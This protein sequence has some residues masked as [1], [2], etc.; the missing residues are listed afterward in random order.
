M[1]PPGLNG[2]NDRRSV[3]SDFTEPPPPEP[4]T[5]RTIGSRSSRAMRSACTCFWKIDASA[6]PP[7]TV[8]SSPPT[9]T[10]AAVDAA[11]SHHE[12]GGCDVD[13][14]AVVVVGGAAGER[15]DLVER[16][17]IEERV[18]ALAHGE[19]ALRVMLGDLLVAAHASRERVAS[20]QLVE[21]GFP[22][23][24]GTRQCRAL[25]T[26][27]SRRTEAEAGLCERL[28]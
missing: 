6:A 11:A 16:A 21:L 10:G 27:R 22:I 25:L 5:R 2:T 18:D 13:D 12:V 14:L 1:F 7:R 9:T 23:G 4:S 26:N 15:A 28:P 8:K 20:R 19:L 3:S 24:H 17:G